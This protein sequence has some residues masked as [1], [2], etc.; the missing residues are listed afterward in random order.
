[1]EGERRGRRYRRMMK[2]LTRRHYLNHFPQ[3]IK[4]NSNLKLDTQDMC[5]LVVFANQMMQS[6]LMALI[7]RVLDHEKE[8]LRVASIQ[9][10]RWHF[11]QMSKTRMHIRLSVKSIMEREMAF[12]NN[13]DR[14]HLYAIHHEGNDY[15]FS[16]MNIT[17]FNGPPLFW[18]IYRYAFPNR[19]SWIPMATNRQLYAVSQKTND[20]FTHMTDQVKLIIMKLC[21]EFTKSMTLLQKQGNLINLMAVRSIQ[22]TSSSL[23]QVVHSAAAFWVPV[24]ALHRLVEKRRRRKTIALVRECKKRQFLNSER[25]WNLC[26]S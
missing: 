24:P 25:R 18:T 7:L 13:T 1:M 16:L 22:Y 10:K 20:R 8:I 9:L 4:M 6:A 15:P 19:D 14:I 11:D 17:E 5:E 3:E 2:W 23:V 12:F 21:E 26:V